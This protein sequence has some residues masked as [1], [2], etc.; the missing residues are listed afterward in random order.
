MN[1]RNC[2]SINLNWNVIQFETVYKKEI[3]TLKFLILF[4]RFSECL[5][6]EVNDE[7]NNKRF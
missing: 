4:G 2:Y 5:Y 3:V 1:M 6:I 7:T